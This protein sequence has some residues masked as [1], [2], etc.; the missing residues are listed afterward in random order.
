MTIPY[1]RDISIKVRSQLDTKRKNGEFIG[2]FA[3][4]GYL[5]DPNNKNKLIVDDYA[6][7]IVQEIFE[8]K[9]EG[10]SHSKIAEKLNNKG[11]L[12]P[13]EYKKHIG[14][15]FKNCLKSKSVSLWS[16]KTIIDI[17]KNPVYIGVLEQAKY[18]TLN[19]RV[20]K[21]I[22]NPREKWLICEDTHQA[23][24]D[25]QTFENV[26][27]LMLSDTRVAPN[28]EKVALFSG[29]LFCGDCKR[30]M[31]RKNYGTKEKRYIYYVC[32]GAVKK[33]GCTRRSVRDKVLEKAVLET[34]K[35]HIK[36]LLDI[37]KI[38]KS[39][40]KTHFSEKQIKSIDVNITTGEKEIEKLKEYKFKVYEDY[41]NDILDK[42]EYDKYN[43]IINKKIEN[44]QKSIE[45][46]KLKLNDLINGNKHQEELTKYLDKY[47]HIKELDRKLVVSLVDKIYVYENLRIC[48][49]FKFDEQYV[50]II[51]LLN[52]LKDLKEVI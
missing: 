39:I 51:N 10:F 20:K 34:I 38:L 50:Q 46:F 41:K 22:K 27:K 1:L 30:S 2:S 52:N 49:K 15:N 31:I 8:M 17:L 18:T 4:Y 28:N 3:A 47:K 36:T 35:I 11:I 14:L 33:N 21:L 16:N 45:D 48:I 40:K 24:I 26:Q 37:E 43:G 5:K 23:I 44:I 12:S 19:Y 7:K 29:V 13:R 9:L 32:S 6:S 42:N 25:K